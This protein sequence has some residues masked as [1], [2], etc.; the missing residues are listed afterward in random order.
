LPASRAQPTT[1][2]LNQTLAI[3]RCSPIL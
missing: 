3:L 1:R 2:R